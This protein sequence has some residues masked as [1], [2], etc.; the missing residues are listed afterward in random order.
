MQTLKQIHGTACDDKPSHQNLHCLHL[1]F[2]VLTETPV[3][4]NGTV[5]IQRWKS[6]LQ[7]LRGGRVKVCVYLE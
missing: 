6:P 7:K 1:F 4:T 5:Q 2:S 3:F